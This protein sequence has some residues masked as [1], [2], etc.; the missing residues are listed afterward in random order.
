MGYPVEMIGKDTRL[1]GII[2]TSAIEHKLEAYFNRYFQE[3]DVDC[4]AMPLNI[5][6]DDIG[7]FLNG[8]KESKIKAVF[9]EPEYWESV[10]QLLG[11]GDEETAFA[12]ACD[13]LEIVDGDYHKSLTQGKALCAMIDEKSSLHGKEIMIISNTPSARSFLY[14][15]IAYKPAKV[16]FASE[17]VEE[18]LEM[19]QFMP[20]HKSYDIIS[21][22][23]NKIDAAADIVVNFQSCHYETESKLNI[24]YHDNLH[25]IMD[26][27]AQIK[28][29]EWSQHG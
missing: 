23:E 3:M 25:Q 8:L 21:I 27:I 19:I 9:F 11:K 2:G 28:T 7:F 16:I 10:Y 1:F 20:D 14:H 26:K 24:Q 22:H 5:R 18:M 12:R 17:V 6:E 4:K 29:K 13:T 15:L